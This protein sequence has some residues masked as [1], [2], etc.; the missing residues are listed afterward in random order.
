MT[1]AALQL[2]K[3]LPA[4]LT[5][6][7][8]SE[9]DFLAL[10]EE[11]PDCFLEY[12]AEG[13]VLIMPPTDPETGACVARVTRRLGNWAEDRGRGIVTGADAGFFF[14]DGSRRS[15]DAAWFDAAR[16]RKSQKKG[17]RFPTFAPEFLIEVRSAEQRARPLR[18]K[19]EEYM[20][21]G[22]QL[23]WLIDPIKNTVEIYRPGRDPEI[24][25]NPATVS[26]EGPV[27]GFVL[28]LKGILTG[29]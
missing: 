5:A 7:G 29:S 3:H 23:G 24:L 13:T 4:T 8:L 22:V 15:P 21:N 20:A 16:W 25:N 12:T 17:T 18:E 28:D 9:A 1:L 14:P 27:E 11:F 26:G 19:M 6:P 10:A 2:E